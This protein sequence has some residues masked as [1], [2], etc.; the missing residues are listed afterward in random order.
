MPFTNLGYSWPCIQHDRSTFTYSW[1]KYNLNLYATM[2]PCFFSF[3]TERSQN[4]VARARAHARL[5]QSVTEHSEFAGSQCRLQNF[6][7]FLCG[8]HTDT[9]I[10]CFFFCRVVN[11]RRT[12]ANIQCSIAVY[13]RIYCIGGSAVIM[14]CTN[15]IDHDA[16]A[17][18]KTTDSIWILRWIFFSHS[19]STF[20]FVRC[21]INDLNRAWLIYLQC[22]WF[23][24][25]NVLNA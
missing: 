7:S 25:F 19:L 9:S 11:S 20:C 6:C 17:G 10:I 23:E 13:I 14:N 18:H 15:R 21:N 4:T 22:I 16:Q 24:F 8:R 3:S 2:I 1:M 12:A 5:R